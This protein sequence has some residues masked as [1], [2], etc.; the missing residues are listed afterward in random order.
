MDRHRPL[1]LG[2]ASPRR[3]AVLEGVGILVRVVSAPVD[4]DPSADETPA[5][6]L[7]RIVLAKLHAA[8]RAS[9]GVY[10]SGLLVADTIVLVDGRILG[11]PS[12][13]E[14]ATRMLS[15]L[16]G[17]SHEVRTRFALGSAAN[18]EPPAALLWAETVVTT[19]WFRALDADEIARYAATGEGLDKAGAYGIQ[20]IG[21]FAVARIDGSYA[22]VVGL[23]IC[24]VVVALKHVG[25]IGPFP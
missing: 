5:A 10:V 11:K 3:R 21:A 13:V 4:E 9:R 25:L 6:Y 17:R 19:V 24:E 15:S 7:E 18:G 14:E 22:N 1:G 16:S 20:G 12:G 2:S 23:P 8:A